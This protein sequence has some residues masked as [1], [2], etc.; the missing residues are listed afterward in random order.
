VLQILSTAI[1]LR[2]EQ[3]YDFQFIS[4]YVSS[5]SFVPPVDLC[6]KFN[7]Y[8]FRLFGPQWS[9]FKLMYT[10]KKTKGIEI[11]TVPYNL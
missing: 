1:E 3:K 4:E 7:F 6:K 2:I 10:L 11:Q 8:V 9:S 5:L